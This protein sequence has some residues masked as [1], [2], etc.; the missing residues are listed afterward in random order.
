MA[1]QTHPSLSSVGSFVVMV[2]TDVICNLGAGVSFVSCPCSTELSGFCTDGDRAQRPAI[3][4]EGHL[5]TDTQWREDRATGHRRGHLTMRGTGGE[6]RET[7]NPQNL[8]LV[9]TLNHFP[10]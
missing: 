4:G 9:P 8:A 1:D 2:F 6:G 3:A 7:G 10:S 5:F